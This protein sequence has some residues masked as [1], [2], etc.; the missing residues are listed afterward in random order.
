MLALVL[1]FE[2]FILVSA[3]YI[4]MTLGLTDQ[5]YSLYPLWNQVGSI[6]HIIGDC[7]FLALY[8]PFLAA[9]LHTKLTRP[10]GNKGVR[11][12]LAV[13]AVALFFTVQLAPLEVGLTL[14]YASMSLLFGFAFVASIHAWYV[15]APGIARDRARSFAIAFG[16]RDVCWGF[17]YAFAI[18]MIR[19]GNMRW[20]TSKQPALP[21]S[22]MCSARSSRSHSLPMASCGHSFSTSTCASAGPSSNR[23]SLLNRLR[24][25]LG[26]SSTDAQTLER[27]LQ[28][29]VA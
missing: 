1:V 12:G 23:R 10:F 5:F 18:W 28:A 16:I 11:I 13:T 24:D 26:I 2:G 29:G 19:M 17:V 9:A 14:L 4:D 6:V 3:G 7:A 21:I 25:S 8:P 27:E 22:S 15:A 20:L